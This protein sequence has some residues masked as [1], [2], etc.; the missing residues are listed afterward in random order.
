MNQLSR[1]RVNSPQVINETIEGEAVIINLA[2]GDYYSLGGAGAEI[3]NA[4][5]RTA[6]VEDI[7]QSLTLG[8]EAD[9]QVIEQAVWNLIEQLQQHGL[10]TPVDGIQSHA[11]SQ[12]R[13]PEAES[14]SRIPFPT[15]TLETYTDMQDL[16]LLDPVH[17]VD[18]RGWPHPAP[19]VRTGESSR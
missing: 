18:E 17:E 16:I 12:P 13:A 4:I 19:G 2:T 7:V 9:R 10:V 6:S 8:Y 3:W 1:F 11:P 5:E 15:P 14:A